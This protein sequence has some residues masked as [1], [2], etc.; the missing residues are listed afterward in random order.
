[1]GEE[2][3]IG[4]MESVK[5]YFRTKAIRPSDKADQYITGHL[6]EYIDEYKLAL[7]TDLQGIDKRIEETLREVRDMQEWKENTEE[8]LKE[9]RHKI[10]RMEQ[11][12]GLKE[13]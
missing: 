4:M 3:K 9:T 10:E 1:M 2:P 13:D 6:P 12:Y 5:G 7:R 11:V 8:R